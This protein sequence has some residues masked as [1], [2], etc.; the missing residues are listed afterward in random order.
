MRLPV[1]IAVAALGSWASAHAQSDS[2]DC[3]DKGLLASGGCASGSSEIAEP[4]VVVEPTLA[5]PAPAVV[6]VGGFVWTGVYFGVVGGRTET[7]NTVTIVQTEDPTTIG[8]V[9]QGFEQE[10][11]GV[12]GGVQAGFSRQFD[13]F[14]LGAEADV[15]SVSL[16]ET[17]SATIAVFPTEMT[18]T[19]TTS[20]DWLSTIRARLGV[21]VIPDLML[22]AAGG[23]A[24]ADVE[25]S[26]SAVETFGGTRWSFEDRGWRVGWT[27][28]GGFEFGVTD[29]ISV[30]AEYIYFNLGD[31]SFVAT[32]D[33]ALSTFFAPN[34]AF[35]DGDDLTGRMARIGLSV[36]F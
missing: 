24:I 33:D 18:T 26:G 6:G 27:I 23:L 12:G 3:F 15:L 35:S 11:D 9:A 36:W 8:E 13:R 30:R 29:R 10:L 1:L 19:E 34:G 17:S 28:G 32:G 16:Q 4:V 2:E 7:E 25:R 14:V 5:A 20:I 21:V 22:F 31:E